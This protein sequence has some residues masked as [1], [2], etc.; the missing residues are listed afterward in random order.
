MGLE[1]G[2]PLVEGVSMGGEPVLDGTLDNVLGCSIG[3]EP[4]ECR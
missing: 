3:M 1:S 2:Y 4:V